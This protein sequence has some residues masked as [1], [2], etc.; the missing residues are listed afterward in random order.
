MRI[1]PYSIIWSWLVVLQLTYGGMGGSWG[2]GWVDCSYRLAVALAPQCNWSLAH[3]HHPAL[4]HDNWN[5]L[6]W[7]L[8]CTFFWNLWRPWEW[9]RN[10]I[11]VIHCI[12]TL[13]TTGSFQYKSLNTT[14]AWLKNKALPLHLVIS[15]CHE[16]NHKRKQ[17]TCDNISSDPRT[18]HFIHYAVKNGKRGKV[19]PLQARLWPR[20]WV[21]V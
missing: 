3:L 14:F 19:T 2:L 5:I 16:Y 20:G 10:G 15:K 18:L 9:F 1:L 7:C 6:I 13:Q 21:E 11:W 4:H 8:S 12:S 17:C